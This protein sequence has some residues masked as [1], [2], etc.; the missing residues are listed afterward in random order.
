MPRFLSRLPYGV[1]TNPV[2][3]FNFEEETDGS[4]HQKYAWSNAAYAMAVNINRLFKRYGW[5]TLIRG[6]ESRRCGREP[7]LPYLPDRRWW[8]GHEV[9]DRDRHFR[10]AARPSCPRTASCR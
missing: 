4:D 3:E 5:C 8:R 6:V 10:T 1:R 7:A 2:D 9:P